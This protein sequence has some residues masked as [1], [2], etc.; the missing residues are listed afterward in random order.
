MP[1][2]NPRGRQIIKIIR[3][4]IKAQVIVSDMEKNEKELRI[5]SKCC[6]FTRKFYRKGIFCHFGD[7]SF[8]QRCNTMLYR[9]FLSAIFF[10]KPFGWL[11]ASKTVFKR[12]HYV[13]TEVK[14]VKN[15]HKSGKT[16]PKQ[17]SQKNYSEHGIAMTPAI[18]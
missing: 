9:Y 8:I 17:R 11:F 12:N 13:K 16:A 15:T 3:I 5:P 7:K 1:L 4:A 6:L 2:T 10:P 18:P 14:C